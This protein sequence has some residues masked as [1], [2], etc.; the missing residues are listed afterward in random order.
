VTS[1]ELAPW[2]GTTT[3][4]DLGGPT[5]VV[6]FDGPPGAPRAVLVHGAGGSL[7]DWLPLVPELRDRF[8]LHA[9]DL[10]GS[11]LSP[12]AGRSP[13]IAAGSAFLGRFVRDVVGGGPV[14]LMGN[15]L[16]GIMCLEYAAR[17]PERVSGVVL[18]DVTQPL[19]RGGDLRV[20]A[21]LLASL[22]PLLP[23]RLLATL[24]ARTDAERAVR[25]GLALA[26]GDADAVPEDLVRAMVEQRRR[27]GPE[28]DAAFVSVARSIVGLLARPWAHRRLFRSIGVPVLMI[29][30]EVDPIIPVRWARTSAAANPTWRFHALPGVGHMPQAEVPD[31]VAHLVLGWRSTGLASVGEQPRA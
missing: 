28:L 10:P 11:G 18:L 14:L 3:T 5:R 6:R 8:E 19:G 16:G 13:S 25:D 30:G 15:S 1:T 22:F 9:L 24:R 29:H 23:Q 26:F 27:Q 7:L 4:A 21:A 31:V 2:G 17:F 20:A 12:L